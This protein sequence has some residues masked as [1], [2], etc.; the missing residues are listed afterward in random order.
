MN[1]FKISNQLNVEHSTK[2]IYELLLL[3]GWKSNT[4]KETFYFMNMVW[5]FVKTFVKLDIELLIITMDNK[6]FNLKQLLKIKI[7]WDI[8]NIKLFQYVWSLS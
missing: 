1:I 3:S 4:Y 7:N 6:S 2:I 8:R 5:R